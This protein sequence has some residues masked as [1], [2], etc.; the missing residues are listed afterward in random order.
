[1]E[2]DSGRVLLG[3]LTDSV[4]QV[5]E[6]GHVGALEVL[7]QLLDQALHVGGVGDADEQVERPPLDGNVVVLD[8]GEDG[9]LVALHGIAVERDHLLQRGERDEPEVVVLHVEE[10]REDVDPVDAQPVRGLDG[11][12]GAHCLVDDGVG[13]VAVGVDVRHELG[14]HVGHL[15]AG[16]GVLLS[17]DF[18][19]LQDLDLEEGVPHAAHLVLVRVARDGQVFELLHEEGHSVF[20]LRDVGGVRHEDI[21]QQAQ[22]A[23]QHA[24]AAVVD[25]AVQHFHELV[26]RVGQ[27]P[28]DPHR[29]RERLLP[30][31]RGLVL[32]ELDDLGVELA[33]H[34]VVG[35]LSDGAECERHHV[36]VLHE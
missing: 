20:E 35:D 28:D 8:A 6:E 15:V 26:D 32:R 12:D 3:D 27:L 16:L 36:D 11:H 31:H 34:F 19:A 5:L 24:R 21:V 33:A 17:E 22:R 4:G 13:G 14:E 30:Q 7:A 23:Q 9:L 29:C 1:M 10:A 18:E 2:L 25:H